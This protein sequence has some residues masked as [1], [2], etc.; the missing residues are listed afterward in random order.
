LIQSQFLPSSSRLSESPAVLVTLLSHVDLGGR[1][2]LPE[3]V[4]KAVDTALLGLYPQEVLAS[5]S[6]ELM[7]LVQDVVLSA[8]P[9]LAL[10]L[11][12][13]LQNGICRWLEDNDNV[14]VGDARNEIVRDILPFLSTFDSS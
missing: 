2:T 11:V 5:A 10:S 14:L 6:L 9:A 12:V 4:V 8:P 7:R 3:T 1:D 13:A